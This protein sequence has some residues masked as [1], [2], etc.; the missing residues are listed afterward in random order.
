MVDR[1]HITKGMGYHVGI[2]DTSPYLSS[3]RRKIQ[4]REPRNIIPMIHTRLNLHM[5]K[6]QV[7]TLQLSKGR[8]FY[9]HLEALG[10][11]FRVSP[12]HYRLIH[13]LH[14]RKLQWRQTQSEHSRFSNPV[15]W[16]LGDLATFLRCSIEFNRQKGNQ[17]SC[18]VFDL[19]TH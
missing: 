5:L 10:F 8:A 18:E 3:R 12:S 16:R 15:R 19:T 6:A 2:R 9:F 11:F 4:W 17:T 1:V 13:L 14:E 7:V